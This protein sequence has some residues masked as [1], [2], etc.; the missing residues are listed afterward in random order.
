MGFAIHRD[1]PVPEGWIGV[2]EA[3]SSVRSYLMCLTFLSVAAFVILA[4]IGWVFRTLIDGLGVLH[5]ASPLE[6]GLL[7]G[8]I[9]AFQSAY[10]YRIK[11]ISIPQWRSIVLG[12]VLGFTS[13][14]SFIFGG[15]LFS[16]FF[17]RHV[18]ELSSSEGAFVL[19]PRV[20]ILLASLFCLYCYSL[21][22]ERLANALQS[23]A[24]QNL[25]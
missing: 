7:I 12:H 22:L 18:P 11:S 20:A 5:R 15:A 17:L 13:R 3:P 23:S 24:D 25:R 16:L 6:L 19:L 4:A 2:R 9:Y 8:A 10:W 1:F 21:E 14:L